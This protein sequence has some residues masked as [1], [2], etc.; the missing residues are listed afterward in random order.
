MWKERNWRKK[1]E[2]KKTGKKR[3]WT[4]SAAD[5]KTNYL[6]SPTHSLSLSSPALRLSLRVCTCVG[7]GRSA[8]ELKMSELTKPYLKIARFCKQLIFSMGS[9]Q[10]AVAGASLRRWKGVVRKK[11]KKGK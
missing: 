11:R 1:K 10:G 8:Q 4:R 5:I 2:K 6:N 9:Y 3:K 7:G